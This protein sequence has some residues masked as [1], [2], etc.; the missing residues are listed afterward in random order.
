MKVH[1]ELMINAK[2]PES[3]LMPWP[4]ETPLVAFPTVVTAS[5]ARTSVP[6]LKSLGLCAIKCSGINLQTQLSGAFFID[7]IG[8]AISLRHDLNRD[9][10]NR[11]FSR[12]ERMLIWG[13]ARE[14][15]TSGLII[16][17]NNTNRRA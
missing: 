11:I 10:D 4:Y 6:V 9:F 15:E 8:N 5:R 12:K 13:K 3:W 7:D 1:K 2:H 14:G 17:D 16:F